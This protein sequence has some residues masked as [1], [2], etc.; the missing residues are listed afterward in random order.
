MIRLSRRLQRLPRNARLCLPQRATRIT[1]NKMRGYGR[2]R[3]GPR[4]G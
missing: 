2:L 4:D 1:P 3:P